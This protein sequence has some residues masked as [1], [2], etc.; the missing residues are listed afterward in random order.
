MRVHWWQ[1]LAVRSSHQQW[2]LIFAELARG[3]DGIKI[4]K[5]TDLCLGMDLNPRFL[6]NGLALQSGAPQIDRSS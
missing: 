5:Q 4:L 1:D 3:A 6:V 2:L